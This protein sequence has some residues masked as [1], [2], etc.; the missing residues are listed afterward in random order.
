VSPQ[1]ENEE[2]RGKE[3][4]AQ[5]EVVAV[6]RMDPPE[7]TPGFL[8]RIGGFEDEEELQDAVRKELER[9]LE[10][11]QQRH[12]RQQITDLLTQAADW[13]LPPDLLRRQSRREMERAVLELRASGF[14][15]EVIRA[16][17][18]QLRQNSLGGTERALKEHFIFE[19]IAEEEGIDASPEDFEAEI[20]LIAR[21]GQESPRRVRARLEKRG[22]MDALRNQIIERKVIGLITSHAAFTDTPF[23]PSK[24]DTAAI[25][26]AV[27]GRQGEAEIPEAKYG[28]EAEELPG[29]T[30]RG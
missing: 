30:E 22:Q 27:S 2:L 9:Q 13:E 10:Y 29:T 15:D 11:H 16:H 3:L 24:D 21:Q 26:E 6:K 17:Q 4:D 7:L 1:A 20:Q 18:N 28:G 12:V 5:F 19:R 23:Q 25:D 14:S 8:D